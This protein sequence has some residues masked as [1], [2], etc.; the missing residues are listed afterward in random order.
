MSEK[1][2]DNSRVDRI[3]ERTRS[4]FPTVSASTPC[5]QPHED[6]L[7]TGKWGVLSKVLDKE[8]TSEPL[9]VSS[10]WREYN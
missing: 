2:L 6:L 3:K 4:E 8:E 7:G 9:F 1:S 5:L 10:I